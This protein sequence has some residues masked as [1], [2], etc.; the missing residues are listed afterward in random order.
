MAKTASIPDKQCI[1]CL[2][3]NMTL[4]KLSN[5]YTSH[6]L[7][8]LG[9][10]KDSEIDDWLEAREWTYTTPRDSESESEMPD[11]VDQIEEE[12][13]LDEQQS[14][15]ASTQAKASD[16]LSDSS[17]E[18]ESQTRNK[19]KSHKRR[20]MDKFE[21]K[22]SSVIIKAESDQ[23][24]MDS[25]FETMS[26][27]HIKSNG[28]LRDLSKNIN[29]LTVQNISS[30]NELRTEQKKN[31]SKFRDLSESQGEISNQLRDL[32]N[33]MSTFSAQSIKSQTE[34]RTIQND[35]KSDIADTK[36]DSDITKQR[37]EHLENCVGL[38]TEK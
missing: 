24:N 27:S 21:N 13:P 8:F 17:S 28:L 10:E 37:V 22:L 7:I 16:S 15:P 19:K 9:G 18:N 35:I 29:E 30:Q 36:S 31:D 38:L 12:G 2:K 20:S 3:S 34:L 23:Q 32:S 5:H 1:I 6:D 33:N 26:A 25:K 11:Q 14:L 4:E